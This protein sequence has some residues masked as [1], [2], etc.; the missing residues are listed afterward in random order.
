MTKAIEIKKSKFENSK[1]QLKAFSEKIPEP[2]KLKTVET[3][4]GPFGWFNHDV[5]GAELNSLTKDIQNQFIVI[6]KNITKSFQEFGQVYETLDALDKEY[7]QSILLAFKAAE[8]ASNQAKDSAATA[9]KNTEDIEKSMQALE[10]IV[11]VLEQFKNKIDRYDHLENIEEIWLNTLNLRN[12]F[13]DLKTSNQLLD[14]FQ[15]ENTERMNKLT[16]NLSS[17]FENFNEIN[18]EQNKKI[19]ALAKK[20]K[21]SYAMSGIAIGSI[22]VGTTLSIMGII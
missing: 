20:I 6:N 5:T 21:L 7:I 4:V 11:K 3:E 22:I 12:D 13:D 17:I 18:F 14:K 10:Q 15:I 9:I 19:D 2:I 1:K 16:N 8:E